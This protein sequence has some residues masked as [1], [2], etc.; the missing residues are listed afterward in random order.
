MQ[1]S[2]LQPIDRTLS[3]ATSPGQSGPG[4]DGNEGVLSI[5]QSFNITET[6]SSDC[7][8]SY[9]GQSLEAGSY[10]FAKKQLVYSIAS[11]NKARNSKLLNC[12]QKKKKLWLHMFS[13]ESNKLETYIYITSM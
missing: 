3:G 7:F 8:V 11:A 6:L 12:V 5:L 9:P 1:F 4:S 10:T 13:E 2:S